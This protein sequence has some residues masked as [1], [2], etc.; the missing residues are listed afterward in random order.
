MRATFSLLHISWY[1]VSS[2]IFADAP[3]SLFIGTGTELICIIAIGGLED[4]FFS[5]GFTA[6]VYR[7]SSPVLEL[8][9]DSTSV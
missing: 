1:A 3:E 9:V 6:I 8:F 2:T 5:V 7:Y 4:P